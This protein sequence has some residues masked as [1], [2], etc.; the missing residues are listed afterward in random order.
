MST[1]KACFL[2]GG[3]L[4][5][6]RRS[7]S[8]KI[9]QQQSSTFPVARKM[10]PRPLTSAVNTTINIQTGKPHR[11]TTTALYRQLR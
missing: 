9:V 3:I 2:L 6:E 8:A 10:S 5:A 1:F 7:F 11:T 4:Q